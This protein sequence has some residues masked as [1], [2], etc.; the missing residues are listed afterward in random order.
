MLGGR[1]PVLIFQFSKLSGT[2]WA[3]LIKGIPIA[4]DI[5][6]YLDQ[7]P[8][9][10]YLNSNYTGLWLDQ[11][12]KNV[13]ISTDME[14]PRQ[15]SNELDSTAQTDVQVNQKIIGSSVT[16]NFLAK[17]TSIGL[18][19]LS[20]LVDLAFARTTS[21]EYAITYLSGPTT[22]F[23]ARLQS[24]NV[25]QNADNTLL[26][27]NMVLT[28]GEK[29]AKKPDQTIVVQKTTGARPLQQP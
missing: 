11:E 12:D 1:D 7:P 22:I 4:K 8:I 19:V 2:T 6:T 25:S 18:T 21:K 26:T 15:T 10:L 14:A 9:P 20:S 5:P 16:V 17:K 13:D 28:V 29:D 3:N 27:V 24:F 23:R